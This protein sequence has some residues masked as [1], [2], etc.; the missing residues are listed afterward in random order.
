MIKRCIVCDEEFETVN[1]K[2]IC[3]VECKKQHIKE[4][5]RVYWKGYHPVDNR[6]CVICGSYFKPHGR[7][8]VCS[9]ECRKDRVRE[10]SWRNSGIDMDIKRYNEMFIEQ[11]GCCAICGRHQSEDSITFHVDHDHDTVEV[12]GLLCK[13]C[14][15]AIGLL[16]D[17]VSV[18][19]AAIEYLN[20]G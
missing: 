13:N 4:Y 16:R 12:R 9:N 10:N 19:K 18:L 11:K 2:K 17:D 1:G 3:S 8:K 14:N 15:N 5:D 7:G 20:K 6:E